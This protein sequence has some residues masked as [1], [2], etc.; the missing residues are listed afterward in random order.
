MRKIRVLNRWPERGFGK[1]VSS[2]YKMKEKG[3]E[4]YGR[5]EKI[6]AEHPQSAV[7]VDSQSAYPQIPPRGVVIF[8]AVS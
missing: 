7:S 4:I 5:R 3:K 2:K 1:A 6:G 8:K